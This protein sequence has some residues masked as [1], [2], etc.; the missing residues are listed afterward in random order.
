MNAIANP[1]DKAVFDA[2]AGLIEL[3]Q[4]LDRIAAK[5]EEPD[6]LYWRRRMALEIKYL[7]E[8]LK[9]RESRT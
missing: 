8:E 2:Q 1:V 7:R 3:W 4:T 5:F 9:A 6:E